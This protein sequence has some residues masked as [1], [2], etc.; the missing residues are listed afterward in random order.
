M[1][2]WHTLSESFV[3]IFILL[4]L[5]SKIYLLLILDEPNHVS[6]I[7]SCEASILET[8]NMNHHPLLWSR[9]EF[10]E[11]DILKKLWS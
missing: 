7:V 4:T 10:P 6:F 1:I 9:R 2:Y 3:S 11:Y 8:Y 5:S